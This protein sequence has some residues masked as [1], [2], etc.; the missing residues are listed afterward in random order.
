[1]NLSMKSCR[2]WPHL[3]LLVDSGKLI[4]VTPTIPS[5]E[6]FIRADAYKREIYGKTMHPRTCEPNARALVEAMPAGEGWAVVGGFAVGPSPEYP[7]RHVWVRKGD[8]HFDPTWSLN[9]VSFVPTFTYSQVPVAKYIYFA[10]PGF[11]PEGDVRESKGLHYLT[12]MADELGIELLE[13]HQFD[14]HR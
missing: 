7:T 5:S 3:M 12:D 11:F 2:I 10:L 13:N 8:A 9:V 14:I 4:S 6:I 1:M